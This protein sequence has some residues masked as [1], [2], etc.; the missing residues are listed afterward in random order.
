MQAAPIDMVK[1]W[2]QD[3]GGPHPNL[4]HSGGSFGGNRMFLGTQH[5]HANTNIIENF[6]HSMNEPTP[7]SSHKEKLT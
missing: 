7:V 4:P 5:A 1:S 2:K 6:E 3:G